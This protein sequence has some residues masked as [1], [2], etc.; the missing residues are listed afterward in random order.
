M[1]IENN[2]VHIR[3]TPSSGKSTLALLLKAFLLESGQN[4]VLIRVW[5]MNSDYQDVLVDVAARD[6]YLVSKDELDTANLVFI[7][8][9]GRISYNDQ[10]F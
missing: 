1:L 5:P 9:E 3:G 2:L 6:R 4:V 10:E 7:I 8:D